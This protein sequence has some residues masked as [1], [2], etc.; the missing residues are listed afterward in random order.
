MDVEGFLYRHLIIVTLLALIILA[1][2]S[3][4]GKI[5][6]RQFTTGLATLATGLVYFVS[7]Q[8]PLSPWTL[9]A[10]GGAAFLWW[11]VYRTRPRTTLDGSHEAL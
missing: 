5:T 1:R 7:T 2:A 9:V 11:L 10:A 3:D 6:D 4:V 8:R